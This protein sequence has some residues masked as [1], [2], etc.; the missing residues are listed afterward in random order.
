M[1]FLVLIWLAGFVLMVV[2][3]HNAPVVPNKNN[4]EKD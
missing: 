1:I 2:E 4:R 3:I